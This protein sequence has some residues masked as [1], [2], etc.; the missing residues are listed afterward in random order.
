MSE[1]S[2]PHRA[3][4][5]FH[6]M[7]IPDGMTII[8]RVDGRG[9]SKLTASSYTKPFDERFAHRMESV[10]AALVTEFGG[11]YGLTHSDEASVLLPAGFDLFGR[12]HE[13]IVT[14]AAGVATQAFCALG[15]FDARVWIGSP[16]DA[17]SYFSWR[18]ESA[19]RNALTD[20]CYWT[21]R[22]EG[23][24]AGQATALLTKATRAAKHDL[25]H[26][27]GINFDEVPGWQKRGTAMWWE[28]FEREGFDPVRKVK[29]TATRRRLR[30]DR[31]VCDGTEQEDL[32]AGLLWS[33]T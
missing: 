14:V 9:F 8:I 7:T 25:L 16:G 17:P 15:H 29:V 4:E 18:Q 1:K 28:T 32:I 24:T 23:K 12:V 10:L 20:W 26:E 6:S 11:I 22:H 13:K 31:G 3:R 5:W 19:L 21:L 33:P 2:S 27:R 30:T